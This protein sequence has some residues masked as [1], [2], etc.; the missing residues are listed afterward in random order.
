MATHL[1]ATGLGVL[2]KT[3]DGC[4]CR[5]A[6]IERPAHGQQSGL[7]GFASQFDFVKHRVDVERC[8]AGG[9]AQAGERN[10]FVFQ[11]VAGTGNQVVQVSR[12]GVGVLA[13]Q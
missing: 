11:T 5:A 8:Q 9:I 1:S 3:L 6:V 4:C 12:I 10:F 7:L 2:V 13:H